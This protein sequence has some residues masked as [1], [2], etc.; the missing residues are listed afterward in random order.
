MLLNVYFI[1]VPAPNPEGRSDS[2]TLVDVY[3]PRRMEKYEE[4]TLVPE[5]K[6]NPFVLYP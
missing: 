6:W 2:Q 3:H 1:V 5:R 4:Y